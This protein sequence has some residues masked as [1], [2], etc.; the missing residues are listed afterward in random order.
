MRSLSRL[1]TNLSPKQVQV[2]PIAF[3]TRDLVLHVM[4]GPCENAKDDFALSAHVKIRIF[5]PV[6]PCENTWDY[7]VTSLEKICEI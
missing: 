6:G 1:S 5:S 3:I 2:D 4:F 7:V